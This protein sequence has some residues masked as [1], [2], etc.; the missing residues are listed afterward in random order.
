M[1]LP[2]QSQWH[3]IFI[4]D[5]AVA[6]SSY[7]ECKLWCEQQFGRQIDILDNRQGVWNSLW[8]GTG[9]KYTYRFTFRD[10]AD[11]VLFAL[12]WS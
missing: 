8:A 7:R 4:S 11:A 9:G 2:D 1:I 3:T 12:R 10:E 6:H 5:D